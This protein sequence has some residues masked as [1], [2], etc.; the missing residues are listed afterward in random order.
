MDQNL[1]P[2]DETVGCNLIFAFKML[3]VSEEGMTL[4]QLSADL[5]GHVCI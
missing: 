4:V 2:V 5:I 3:V 1:K